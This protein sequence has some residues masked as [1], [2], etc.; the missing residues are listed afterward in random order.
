MAQLIFNHIN[1]NEFLIGIKRLQNY[2]FNK[3]DSVSINGFLIKFPPLKGVPLKARLYKLCP[4][5]KLKETEQ[6]H[7]ACIRSITKSLAQLK[8]FLIDFKNNGFVPKVFK[9]LKSM[10]KQKLAALRECWKNS[11]LFRSQIHRV[12]SKKSYTFIKNNSNHNNNNK[13]NCKFSSTSSCSSSSASLSPYSS[14]KSTTETSTTI[15]APTTPSTI[16]SANTTQTPTA[17]RIKIT[18]SRK[19][20][21]QPITKVLKSYM[22]KKYKN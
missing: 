8:E 14:T 16:T 6:N 10:F 20:Y 21:G 19:Y 17:S 2:D 3:V 1:Y 12:V 11:K 15:S 13:K 22:N 18:N 4:K 9:V 7:L 5:D